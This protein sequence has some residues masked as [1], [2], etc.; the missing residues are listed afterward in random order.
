MPIFFHALSE[1]DFGLLLLPPLVWSP[2]RCSSLDGGV[3]GGVIGSPAMGLD[4]RLPESSV[5]AGDPISTPVHTFG[6]GG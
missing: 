1:R 2:G 3:V 5:N 4:A 6:G